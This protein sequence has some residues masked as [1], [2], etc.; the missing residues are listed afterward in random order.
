LFNTT[1]LVRGVNASARFSAVSRQYALPVER[2]VLET[3][4]MLRDGATQL[5]Q[6]EHGRIL[7]GLVDDRLGRL[8]PN[9]LRP[10]I[11]GK[12]L[13]QVDGAGLAGKGRHNLEDR[14]RQTGEK[15]IHRGLRNER[16]PS[17]EPDGILHLTI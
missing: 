2:D 16:I 6:P 15:G 17:V 1:T 11:V 7:I 5:R 4:V 9:I 8:A 14:G 3:P 10:L 13:P 12:S